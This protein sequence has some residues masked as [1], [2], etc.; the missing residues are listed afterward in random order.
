MRLLCVAAAI[1]FKG[2]GRR[3]KQA[4]AS[5]NWPA[6]FRALAEVVQGLGKIGPEGQRIAVA[7]DAFV[8]I[9]AG[10]VEGVGQVAQDWADSG[11]SLVVSR[12][13]ATAWSRWPASCSARPRLRRASAHLGANLTAFFEHAIAWGVSRKAARRTLARL[14]HASAY[15]GSSSEGLA[16]SRY[17]FV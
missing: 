1:G 16:I 8:N 9:P 3:S 5:S 12:N 6:S 11:S 4:R 17:R 10:V 7:G 2:Q 14:C 15:W 13:S